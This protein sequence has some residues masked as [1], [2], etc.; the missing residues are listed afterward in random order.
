[1]TECLAAYDPIRPVAPRARWWIVV[2]VVTA[3]GLWGLIFHWFFMGLPMVLGHR[4]NFLVAAV[5]V[6]GVILA[7]FVLIQGYEQELAAAAVALRERNEALRTLEAERDTRLLDL[8]RDLALALVEI[9]NQCEIALGMPDSTD[10]LGTLSGVKD[11][12]DQIHS[13]VRS[14]IELRQEGTGL[15]EF[16]SAVLEDYRR[17]RETQAAKVA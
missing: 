9:S 15:T 12:A 5:L 17:F 8:A 6:T 2:T 11:R 13:V 7:F 14:L 10:T 16:L 3:L 4:V 1:M